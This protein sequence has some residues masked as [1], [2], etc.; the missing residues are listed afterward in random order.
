[1]EITP[2]VAQPF[3][4]PWIGMDGIGFRNGIGIRKLASLAEE[5]V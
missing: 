2:Q 5:A 1:M 4:G 3:L